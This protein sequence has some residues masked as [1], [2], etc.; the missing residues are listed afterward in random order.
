MTVAN[1]FVTNNSIR[2]RQ[3][4]GDSIIRV[5]TEDRAATAITG[6][7]FQHGNNAICRIACVGP[8]GAGR[9][10]EISAG[11]GNN[12]GIVARQYTGN[13][14]WETIRNEFV[15]LDR[16]GNSSAPNNLIVGGNLTVNG[17]INNPALDSLNQ[18][19]SQLGDYM[20]LSEASSMFS[21]LSHTHSDLNHDISLNINMNQ[22]ERQIMWRIFGNT[23]YRIL[24][25]SNTKIGL[26]F[27]TSTNTPFTFKQ[28]NRTLTLLDNN[29]NTTIPGNLTVEGNINTPNLNVD[30]NITFN[31]NR[32]IT[33]MCPYNNTPIRRI[34]GSDNS[35]EGFEFATV[36]GSPVYVR[37]YWG[38]GMTDTN[39]T[40]VTLLDRLG[41][42]Q[43]PHS[44]TADSYNTATSN[45][46]AIG[47]NLRTAIV[48]LIY[49]IGAYYI[50][51]ASTSPQTLFGGTW[52][53]IVNRFLYCASS[54]GITGGSRNIS[55]ANLPAHNHGASGLS[56]NNTGAHTHGYTTANLLMNI[57]TDTGHP[58]GGLRNRVWD[59]TGSAGAHSHTISGNTANTG[60]GTEYMPEHITVFC[61]RRTG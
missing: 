42:A 22:V 23:V 55:V 56:T 31:P 12:M 30:G 15:I 52:E 53:Q 26:E 4:V 34:R 27:S 38:E 5:S 16:N 54:A 19:L 7:Y 41:H 6:V 11:R 2:L 21:R 37:Q 25:S 59:N 36:G 32:D 29:G 13:G 40:T 3:T 49:P 50:S 39:P 20:T 1:D 14:V 46:F 10:I 51:H 8:N 48:N 17:T 33:W 61:W 47:A 9:P 44:V 35:V 43:F 24:G 57:N 28:P 58:S 18:H 45:P 60:S